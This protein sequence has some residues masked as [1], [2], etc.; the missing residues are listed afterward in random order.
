MSHHR[1][2]N[3]DDVGNPAGNALDLRHLC[4]RYFEPRA[5]ESFRAEASRGSLTWP[6]NPLPASPPR[7]H[8]VEQ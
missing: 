8:P 7:M 4:G 2:V 1:E 5:R 6:Q 3:H